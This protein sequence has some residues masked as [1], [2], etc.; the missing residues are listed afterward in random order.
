M[1]KERRKDA[2]RKFT[3]YM[4]VLDAGTQQVI[5]YLTDISAVGIKVDS[6]KPL[7]LDVK[8]ALRMDLTAD[9]ANKTS[10]VF[11]AVSKWCQADSFEPNTYNIGFEV[12]LASHDDT[13]IFNRMIEKY[14]LNKRA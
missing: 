8:Y 11:N 6:D 9:V 7:P 5:G 4:R 1:D 14:G 12:T 2:R 13:Q 3:Y 10:M